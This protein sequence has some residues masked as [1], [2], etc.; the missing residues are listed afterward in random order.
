MCEHRP[1]LVKRQI[2]QISEWMNDWIN[3]FNKWMNEA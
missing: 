3:K 2:S 1:L